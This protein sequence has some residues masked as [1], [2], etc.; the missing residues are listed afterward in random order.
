MFGRRAAIIQD[1]RGKVNGSSSPPHYITAA[2]GYCSQSIFW[3]LFFWQFCWCKIFDKYHVWL[4][5]YSTPSHLFGKIPVYHFFVDFFCILLIFQSS[6]NWFSIA[7][8]S[9]DCKVVQFHE[10]MLMTPAISQR[11]AFSDNA[12]PMSKLFIFRNAFFLTLFQSLIKR[13]KVIS[14]YPSIPRNDTHQY[15]FVWNT[16]IYRCALYYTLILMKKINF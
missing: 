10:R 9:L 14:P 13:Y 6:S 2:A 4:P 11:K 3:T 5:H 15:Y 8:L 1:S 16:T 7:Y 12:S